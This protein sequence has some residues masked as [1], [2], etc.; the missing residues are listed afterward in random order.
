M[1]RWTRWKRHDAWLARFLEEPTIEAFGNGRD[2]ERDFEL[3]GTG[4]DLKVTRYPRSLNAYLKPRE[5]A[6]WMYRNQSKEGRFHLANRIFVVATD[7]Q[8][9]YRYS[10][11]DA[12]VAAFSEAP[13]SYLIEVE[14]GPSKVVQTAV[15]PV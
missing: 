3:A 6:K 7:E 2:K 4:F 14:L 8:D 9:L 1:S 13:E 5:I 15:L 11:A 12:T 10:V